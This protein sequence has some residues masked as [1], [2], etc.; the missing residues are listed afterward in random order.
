MPTRNPSAQVW[1]AKS[2]TGYKP[3]RPRRTRGFEKKS[4]SK[5]IATD[6]SSRA[7]GST[8]PPSSLLSAPNATPPPS[9]Q[10][11][12]I[13]VLS[14]PVDAD[15]HDALDLEG[16]AL[17]DVGDFFEALAPLSLL[18]CPPNSIYFDMP[19]KY[20]NTKTR[21]WSEYPDLSLAYPAGERERLVSTFL[22]G[23]HE[24]CR[25]VLTERSILLPDE[26]YRWSPTR[27]SLVH[28]NGEEAS[29]FGA[30]LV[31]SSSEVKWPNVLCDIQV[32]G[33]DELISEAVQ[34]LS[35]TAAYVFATQDDCIYHVG[36]A[37]AGDS[38]AVVMHDRAGRVQCHT[39]HVHRHGILLVRLVLALTL[40]K[41]IRPGRDP[42]ILKRPDGSRLLCVN[43]V[44]YEIVE[45]LFQSNSIRGRGT[46]CWRCR[47]T[48]NDDDYVIKSTW[49]N[50]RRE[51]TEISFFKQ[52]EGV[53]GIP[54]LIDHEVVVDSK[55]IPR[56]TD[57]FRAPLL[58]SHRR[59]ELRGID[60]LHLHRL[61]MQPFA[62]PLA[63]FSSK[64][65]LLSAI[66]DAVEAHLVLCE[67]RGILHNDISEHN[68]M[69]RAQASG[70]LRRGLLIDLDSATHYNGPR[71]TPHDGHH[72]GTLPFMSFTL[73]LR[74]NV[75]H[76]P[77]HDLE[78]FLYVLMWI[79]T[80]YAGPMSAREPGFDPYQSPMGQWFSGDPMTVGELK[81]DI[82]FKPP[83]KFRAFLDDT[84]DPYFDDLKDCVCEIRRAIFFRKEVT[85]H[86]E[87]YN[88]LEIHAYC[89]TIDWVDEDSLPGYGGD[90]DLGESLSVAW[91]I[92]S[93]LESTTKALGTMSI[94]KPLRDDQASKNKTSSD[95]IQLRRSS[96]I[97]AKKRAKHTTAP[98]VTNSSSPPYYCPAFHR[99]SS[100]TCPAPIH[101]IP[102]SIELHEDDTLELE[103]TA[104]WRVPGVTGQ[105]TSHGNLYPH[106]TFLNMPRKMYDHKAS[107]WSHYPCMT[108]SAREGQ[109]EQQVAAFLNEIHDYYRKAMEQEGSPL[110]R[111]ERRWSTVRSQR[112]L[113][114]GECESVYGVVLTEAGSNMR[115]GNVLCDVQVADT[116]N[117]MSDVVRRLSRSAANVFAAQDNCLYHFGLAFAGDDLSVVVHDRAGRV[118]SLVYK[119]H[120]QAEVLVRVLCSLMLLDGVPLGRDPTIELREGGTRFITVDEIEYEIVD[121]LFHNDRVRGAGTICWR[122]RRPGEEED[123][124]IKST[125]IRA[126]RSSE[127]D[128]LRLAGDID[129]IPTLIAHE[130]VTDPEEGNTISTDS[131]RK[132]LLGQGRKDEFMAIGHM[133]L[134]R[135]VTQ[136]YARPLCDFTS[137][138]ELLSGLR[139]AV[140]AHYMLFTQ[141]KAL[142]CDISEQN[143]ML[144]SK[145]ADERIRRGLLIDLDCATF[146]TLPF[147]STSLLL[148]PRAPHVAA[149]DLESFLYVLMWICTYYAGPSSTRRKGYD[150][151]N[152][153][154]GQWFKD[155]IEEV[156]Q[157][158]WTDVYAKPR[159]E[160]RVFLDETFHPYFD[161]L[162]DCVCE[163]RQAIVCPKDDYCVTHEDVLDILAR[164]IQ[165]Q[166][167]PELRRTQESSSSSHG[168]PSD[169]IHGSGGMLS[170]DVPSTSTSPNKR[171]RTKETSSGG[172][173]KRRLTT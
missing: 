62:I 94:Q 43:G 78:S 118:Q 121:R 9:Q 113:P 150:W 105:I 132:G 27:T 163:L 25:N 3:Y 97:P 111:K 116:A 152:S 107:Q 89:R 100:P 92:L 52:A 126:G 2:K 153:P 137:K 99:H 20:F 7:R 41:N 96:R 26:E 46:V 14:A 31:G 58:R 138:E 54:T 71:R 65:E 24:H 136:P 76:W 128:F 109:R 70:Q 61:V 53:N 130:L 108:R 168:S 37:F 169:T 145:D 144:R 18:P 139:D 4:R 67:E 74:P 47:K 95:A 57:L 23:I 12:A 17:R 30:V 1:P 60:V 103:K 79:C 157:R 93:Q 154:M 75:P 84:F 112:R 91:D 131:F 16:T 44:E 117:L 21:R 81:Q 34:K 59:E 110:P 10:P 106:A 134:H 45:R 142:H 122:C 56:P 73:L 29:L 77:I 50:V 66:R 13:H 36:F 51:E 158:K 133:N 141:K 173:K 40:A 120:R 87:I 101:K 22:D 140:E 167:P 48:G 124:I 104:L 171:K 19:P 146:G 33:S 129:G 39:R 161:D 114:D 15:L 69:L 172:A 63:E 170:S 143:I 159:K 83:G 80:S 151:R 155:S 148:Q 8:S 32:V 165:A 68:V 125:W 85:T 164:H 135:L 64:E 123:Y 166:Q 119:V 162:K 55:G 11:V 115:W 35:T 102:H 90:R 6:S 86:E 72:L 147:M 5:P 88:I 42:A 127:A 160:F 82:M 149:H 28:S 49:V 38:F 156:G 98:G